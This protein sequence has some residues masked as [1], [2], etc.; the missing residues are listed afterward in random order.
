M[1]TGNLRTEWRDASTGARN[2]V[3]RFSSEASKRSD[4]GCLRINL[5]AGWVARHGACREVGSACGAGI[6]IDVRRLP[7]GLPPKHP[8]AAL[9]GQ[10]RASGLVPVSTRPLVD[11]C[12][13]KLAGRAIKSGATAGNNAVDKRRRGRTIHTHYMKCKLQKTKHKPCHKP[14]LTGC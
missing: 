10:G 1:G 4:S 11:V 6:C 14:F 5:N 2:T 9:S 13:I 12:T 7:A 3:G 8:P